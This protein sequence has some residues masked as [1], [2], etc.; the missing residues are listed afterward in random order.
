MKEVW[1]AAGSQG[2]DQQTWTDVKIKRCISSPT[3]QCDG[4][5]EIENLIDSV[6]VEMLYMNA[7]FDPK[8]LTKPITYFPDTSLYQEIVTGVKQVFNI[9]LRRESATIKDSI[10]G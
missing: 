10:W 5:N 4:E 7:F 8:S 9:D 1:L 6:N 2:A 3:K